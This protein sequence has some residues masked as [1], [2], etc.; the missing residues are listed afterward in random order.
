MPFDFGPMIENNVGRFTIGFARLGQ[1][2]ATSAGSGTLMTFGDFGG[3]LTCAH[4][5][6][7]LEQLDEFGIICFPIRPD[8]FQ[9]VRVQ[10][11]DISCVTI[12]D[13]PWTER[14]PDIGF[15]RLPVATMSEIAGVASII[16]A[17]RQYALVTGV[18]PDSKHCVDVVSGVIDDWTGTTTVSRTTATTPF[19]LLLNGG[20]VLSV[21]RSGSHDLVDFEPV[22]APGFNLPAS[23]RGTSGGGLWRL[24]TK[25]NCDDTFSLV[26]RR[27]VGV[28]FW[29][30][31]VT[32]HIIC[33]GHQSLYGHLITAIRNRW[34]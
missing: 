15:V 20:R 24:Y 22:P 21:S 32:R 14:G 12:E 29:E 6:E 28:A 26:Q 1:T 10:T 18:E 4:V 5:V 13:R 34:S 9:T 31:P 2:S 27:L 33:H 16:D 23:Y 25:K 17:A 3:V 11:R 7:A 30:T 19:E 8:Q